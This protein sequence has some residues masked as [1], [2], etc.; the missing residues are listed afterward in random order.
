MAKLLLLFT[1]V[2]IVELVVLL[3][4]GAGSALPRRCS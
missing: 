3:E 1:V 4:V 2:R